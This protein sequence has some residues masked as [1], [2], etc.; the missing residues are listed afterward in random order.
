MVCGLVQEVQLPPSRRHSNVDPG[1]PAL[2]VKVGVVSFEGLEGLESIVV[3]GAVRSTVQ[4]WLAGDPSVL[5]AWSVA[6]TSKVWLPS[7]RAGE[8]VSGLVQDVQLPLSTRH[9]KLEPGSLE[10]KLK[11]GVASPD[12]FD[13]LESMVVFGAVRSSV[14]LWLADDPSV[15]PAWSVARTSKLWLPAPSAAS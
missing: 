15:F 12:G 13:G 4:V 14:Q 2:K 5:P 6:R 1:S 11:L 3:S 8:R 9:S 7:V 10:L